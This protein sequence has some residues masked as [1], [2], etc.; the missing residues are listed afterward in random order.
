VLPPEL[1]WQ[2]AQSADGAGTLLDD[3]LHR[4]PLPPPPQAP[5]QRW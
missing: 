2:A 3:W 4:R 1:L 5:A